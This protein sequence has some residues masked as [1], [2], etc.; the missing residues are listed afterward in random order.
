M[1]FKKKILVY[2]THP[3]VQAWNFLPRHGKFL[4][5][6]IPGLKISICLDL[7][8]F[9]DLL[10]E[11]EVIVVWFFNSDWLERASNLKFIFT[12][13]AGRDWIKVDTNI[14]KVF[15]GKFHGPMIAESVIGAVFYF[16]KAFHFS[17]KMQLRK[18]WARM[19]ISERLSSLKGS[20]ITILGFGSIGQCIGRFLKPYG[21]TITGIKRT[22]IKDPDYF[23]SSDRITIIENIDQVLE[24]T[25]HLIL[26][27]PGGVETQGILTYE[28]LSKLP[29]HCYL[30]NIGRGSVYEERDL[31][32]VLEEK[33]I[34]GAYLDVF[35]NEPLSEK[36]FFW[37][38]DNVLIQPHISAASPHY[39]DLFVEEIAKQIK[40][41]KENNLSR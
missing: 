4:E 31:V 32:A 18:K 6:S 16:L 38:M 26:A 12:P 10:P 35:S 5:D 40:N 39:L 8:E 28:L 27:L 14:V 3:H 29:E 33:K 36:S 17:K 24:K 19:K 20:R 25:D 34:A 21:C 30:Y 22:F 15:N 1:N 9:L 37:E 13:A 23:E 2:L 7:K 11:A 41:L